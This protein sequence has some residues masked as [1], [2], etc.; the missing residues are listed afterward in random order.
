MVLRIDEDSV[1]GTGC[2]A[3]FAP[4][5]DRFVKIDNSVRALEHGCGR[6]RSNAGSMSTLVAP[7]DLVGAARLREYTHVNMFDVCAGY[8]KGNKVLGFA[9]SRTG[10][11]T[12]ATRVVDYLGPTDVVQLRLVE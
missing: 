1:V 6:T 5:A 12:N 2:H 4:N 11:A 10:V 9:G 8:G 3:R 7:R